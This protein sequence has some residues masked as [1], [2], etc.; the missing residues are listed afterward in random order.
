MRSLLADIGGTYARFAVLCD[1]ELGPIHRLDVRAFPGFG[2]AL[3]CLLENHPEMPSIDAAILAVAGPVEQ[4]VCR[5]TN[6]PWVI[7]ATEL[8][9]EFGFA[10]VRLVNDLEAVGMSLPHLRPDEFHLLGPNRSREEQPIAV[11][12][13]GTGLGMAC[14][15]PSGRVVASEG[16]HATLAAGSDRE[17]ALIGALRRRYG[18]V[19][20][21][22]VLSGDGL[23]NLYREIATLDARECAARTAPEI[24]AAALSGS[25]PISR[26]AV[27]TFCAFLGAV[28]GDVALFFGARGGVFIGGGIVPGIV[29]HLERTQFRRRFEAKGRFQAYVAAIPAMVVLRPD[30]A[31]LGLTALAGVD[32]RRCRDR[33]VDG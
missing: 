25:C 8:K 19:S 17:A 31:F 5:L 11:L 21:E 12:S 18:H 22:R 33:R 16:G 30:P 7:D 24:T 3:R 23:V 4:C 20:M 1:D 15:L 14:R 9:R 10:T 27:D 2:P 6:S 32:A 26:E 29:G 28:A 13:P